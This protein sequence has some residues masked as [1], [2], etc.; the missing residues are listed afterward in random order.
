MIGKLIVHG[1][2]REE[3]INRAVR[4]LEEYVIDGVSTTVEFAIH[5]L[6][7]EDFRR[8]NYH[9]GYLEHLLE[10]GII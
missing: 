10:T 5:L 1:N 8:G 7:R 2:T 9:T 6:G 3:A 4:A